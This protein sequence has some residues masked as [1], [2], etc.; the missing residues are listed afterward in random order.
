MRDQ[1]DTARALSEFGLRRADILAAAQQILPAVPAS[2]P[3]HFDEPTL[4][5]LLTAAWEGA[6]PTEMRQI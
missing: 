6:P 5:R 1:A 4:V 2:N 3:S